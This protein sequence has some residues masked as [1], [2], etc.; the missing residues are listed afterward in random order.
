VCSSKIPFT[1]HP[2]MLQYVIANNIFKQLMV[3]GYM[4]Y[5]NILIHKI[6]LNAVQILTT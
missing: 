1:I 4:F 2:S 6:S 5:K 3:I